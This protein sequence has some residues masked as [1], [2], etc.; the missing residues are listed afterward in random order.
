[1][2]INEL[3]L[4]SFLYFWERNNMLYTS[5]QKL[6]IT[7]EALAAL[8]L[9]VATSKTEEMEIVKQLIISILNRE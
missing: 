1:M 6:L 5:E 3:V 2:E 8:T 9:F 7:N 4:L